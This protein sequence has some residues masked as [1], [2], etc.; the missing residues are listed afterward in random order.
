[1]ADDDADDRYLVQAAFEDNSF[2]HELVFFEDGD[3]LLS[4]L[5]SLSVEDI[6]SFIL[7]DLNMPKLDGRDILK[8]LKSDQRFLTIPIIVFST[9][10]APEDVNSCYK[11]GA[12]SYVV[13]PSG[14][15][16]LKDTILK[17]TDFWLKVSILPSHLV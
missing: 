12:N 2:E 4:Y 17:I 5:R 14:Y 13:K 1:M 16:E 3:Q 6:P 10:K 8:V 9:S 11:L 7:L 15:E